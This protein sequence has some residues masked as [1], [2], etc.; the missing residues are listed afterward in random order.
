MRKNCF[1]YYGSSNIYSEC[2]YC[3]IN[4][5]DRNYY[6]Q[7]N[8]FYSPP[9]SCANHKL[10]RYLYDKRLLIELFESFVTTHIKENGY[11]CD[12]KEILLHVLRSKFH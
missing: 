10:E 12:E 6:C 1:V 2:H 9:T 8:R 11:H 4:N 3:R 7:F 5:R